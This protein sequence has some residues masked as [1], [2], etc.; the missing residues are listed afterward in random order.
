MELLDLVGI[1]DA[2]NRLSDFPHQFS[3]GLRQQLG[4][5]RALALNPDFIVCDE[6]IAA[7]DASIQ[8][9]VVNLLEQLQAQFG[10]TYLFISRALSM[11]RH[12]ADRVAA[13][14]LGKMMEL[15]SSDAL[16]GEPL[17]PYTQALLSAVP[18]H[19]PALEE[20]RERII[21]TGD[22]P[23]PSNPPPGCP[24]STRCCIAMESDNQEHQLTLLHVLDHAGR[25]AEAKQ[26]GESMLA[27]GDELSDEIRPR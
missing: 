6:P 15:A 25:T 8:A 21:P 18:I 13:I 22:V 7:L 24:F 4:I 12:I 9:Q 10:L 2:K 27:R 17:Y 1:P 23:N 3:G 5:A 16:Y 20:K 19:D 11:M 26:L 14:Y